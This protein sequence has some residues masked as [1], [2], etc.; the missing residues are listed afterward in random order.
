MTEGHVTE[1]LG[2]RLSFERVVETGT[3]TCIIT[4]AGLQRQ[5]N[6]VSGW[7]LEYEV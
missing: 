2:G 5:I 4:E 7:A 6:F 3:T 1:I